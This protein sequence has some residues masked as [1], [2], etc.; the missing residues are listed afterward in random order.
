MTILSKRK[1]GQG[2]YYGFLN[3]DPRQINVRL[4]PRTSANDYWIA[5]VG[6]N[7]LPGFFGSKESAEA[8]AIK[9][10]QANPENNSEKNS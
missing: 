2:F 7:E 5:Y 4:E 1:D 6:G 8:A 10:A 9:W 3:S